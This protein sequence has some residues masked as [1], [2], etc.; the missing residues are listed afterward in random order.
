MR[1]SGLRTITHLCLSVS[2]AI[3]MVAA[4]ALDGMQPVRAQ[5]LANLPLQNAGDPPGRVGRVARLSGT[6][7]FHTADAD[8]WEPATLNYPVTSGNAFWTQP[9]AAADID[10]GGGRVR[11]DQGTEFT[12][13]TLDD[14][15]I[16]ATVGQGHLALDLRDL[17]Q[18][19]T[20]TLRTPR[21][22]VT[23]RQAGRYAVQVGD[24][25]RPTIVTVDE[26]AAGVEA[27]GLALSLGAHQ[28]AEITGSDNFSGVVVAEAPDALI[29][30]LVPVERP[31]LPPTAL[32]PPPDV[33]QMTG[34]EAIADTGSW[35]QAPEYGSVWYPPVE[36][37]WVPYRQG[38]WSW[39]APWGWTWVDDAPW[40][41]APSHYGRWVEINDR[42]AWTPHEYG[43]SYVGRPVYA[44]ALVTFLGVAAGV[45]VGVGVAHAVGWIPLG[46]REAYRPPY[47]AS[48]G[49]GRR[50]NGGV[51]ISVNNTVVTSNRFVNNRAAT[52]VPA[53]AMQQSL[54][55]ANR[56]LPAAQVQQA[57]LQPMPRP[58]VQPSLSTGGMT[59]ATAQTMRLPSGPAAGAPPPAAPGP[60]FRRLPG[61]GQTGVVS[62]GVTQPGRAASSV[63]GPAGA[64]GG[65]ANA[66]VNAPAR[67]GAVAPVSGAAPGPPIAPRLP[68]GG[69]PAPT[70]GIGQV[71][72]NAG[73]VPGSGPS[74][75]PLSPANLPQPQPQVGG[76]VTGPGGGGF[77]P[78]PNPGPSPSIGPQQGPGAPSTPAQRGPGQGGA[79]QQALPPARPSVSAPVAPQSIPQTVAPAPRPVPAP[80]SRPAPPPQI[81]QQPAPRQ[82][83]PPQAQPRPEPPRPQ[84]AP[85]PP[86]ARPQP[87]PPPPQARPQPAPPP[88]QSRPQPA[89]PP[90]P[91]PQPAP[92]PPPQAR[93]QPAP[94]EQ[95]QAPAAHSGG[96]RSCPP[97]RQNC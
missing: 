18:G 71:R 23:F 47:R 93:P 22:V 53:T 25:N 96:Q 1:R 40:G 51:P 77:G 32:G 6:V 91:R 85:P 48:E 3:P 94:Q 92:P 54:P 50:V 19:E 21:G 76:T 65:A 8:R 4:P 34:Y 64:V 11:L 24:T 61:G 90:Q 17:P 29:S 75:S 27:P 52:V 59:P 79:P 15:T 2:L 82:S 70:G 10:L 38:R 37:D 39:V 35:E 60:A 31:P 42:W 84:P 80:M 88:P 5:S 55:V 43:R 7:S 20:A 66:P 74:G 45:A 68:G 16:A 95:R 97:G 83:P 78:R 73:P 89:P 9:G 67:Q 44:P 56:V 30:A 14:Q 49:Y 87:A 62:P 13:D 63:P 12:V 41:F 46:P 69:G 81:V 86:Q 72:P 33:L 58:P 36:R 28:A 57:A 26:G